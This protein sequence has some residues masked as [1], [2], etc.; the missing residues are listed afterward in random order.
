MLVHGYECFTECM[1]ACV[2]LVSLEPADAREGLWIPPEHGLQ[3]VVSHHVVLGTEPRASARVASVPNQRQS[4]CPLTL[5][6]S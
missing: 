6:R 2:P 5:I 3:M 4:L 1:Y